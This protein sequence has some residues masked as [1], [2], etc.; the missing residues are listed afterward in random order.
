M[1]NDSA[2]LMEMA[3]ASY[4]VNGE[5]IKLSPVIVKKYLVSGEDRKSVV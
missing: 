3:Q 2:D 5:N 1:R 4:E